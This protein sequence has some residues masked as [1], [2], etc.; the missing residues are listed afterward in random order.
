MKTKL[1]FAALAVAAILGGCTEQAQQKYD[2]AGEAAGAAADKTGEAVATD[3]KV[4]GEAAANAAEN[5]AEAADNA[6]DTFK[7]KN[8]ILAADDIDASDLNV[9]TVDNKVILKGMVPTEDQKKRAGD[10]AKG[11]VGAGQTVDNQLTVGKS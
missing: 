7:I 4:A 8:A 10:I 11:M 1:M 9:D 2:Q 3:A 5:T 6:G